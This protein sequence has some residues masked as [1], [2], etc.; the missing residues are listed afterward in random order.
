MAITATHTVSEQAFFALLQ[1]IERLGLSPHLIEYADG[2]LIPTHA[3][4]PFSAQMLHLLLETDHEARFYEQLPMPVSRH[5][6]LINNLVFRL[7]LA[8][9][10]HELAYQV[11]PD[12]LHIFVRPGKY[13]VPD[14]TLAAAGYTL[15][16]HD[17]LTD[18]VAIFEVASP[19]TVRKDQG[20]KLRAYTGI[21]SLQTYVLVSQEEPLVERY[22][23]EDD[24]WKFAYFLVED[25]EFSLGAIPITLKIKDLYKGV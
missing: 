14:V 20:E 1:K 19:S 5:T 21:Q 11:F 8:L 17:Q 12:G 6:I 24:G 15:N 7:N 18:P 23:R 2:V 16:A 3:D 13:Y 25:E 4:T 10:Q 9:E 22:L